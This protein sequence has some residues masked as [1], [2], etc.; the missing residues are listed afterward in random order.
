MLYI[1]EITVYFTEV[2]MQLGLSM[3]STSDIE[4]LRVLELS[5]KCGICLFIKLYYLTVTIF[6]ADFN[7]L[8]LYV[9][10][11]MHRKSF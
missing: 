6:N 2:K 8:Y 11:L 10:F 1:L 9:L 4:I 5:F 7:R 3:C